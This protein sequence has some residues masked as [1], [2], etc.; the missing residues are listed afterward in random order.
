MHLAKAIDANIM[1]SELVKSWGTTVTTSHFKRMLNDIVGQYDA[2]AV[3]KRE[4]LKKTMVM[5]ISGSYSYYR[6]GKKID[7][8]FHLDHRRKSILLNTRL[9]NRVIFLTS[10]TLQHELIHKAQY[11]KFGKTFYT[12]HIPVLYSPYVQKKRKDNIKYLSLREEVDCFAQNIAM[13]LVYKY[14]KESPVELFKTLDKRNI[15]LYNKYKLVF[16]NTD[17]A[18][19]KKVLLKKIWKWLPKVSVPPRLITP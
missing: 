6:K 7:I 18:D 17:W 4:T 12:K 13:E 2:K 19:L 11:K 16:K 10:Q 15:S 8:V 14:P 9:L 3:I 5:K 1:E